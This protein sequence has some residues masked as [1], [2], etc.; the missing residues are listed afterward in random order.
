MSRSIDGRT[1]CV[2]GASSGMGRSIA[3]HLGSLGAHVFLAGRTAP[4][5]EES[6]ETIR[7]AG[8]QADTAVFDVTD[9]AALSAWIAGAAESTGRLDVMVNNAGFGDVGSTIADG[10]PDSWRSMLEVNV[11]ALA[12]G[13]QAAIRAMRSTGSEGNIINI[14][15]TASIRRES[16][17][18]GATKHAV[19]CI[20]GTLRQ[21]LEDDPI[22]VTAILPGAFA[23]NFTRS[24]DRELVS[25]LAAMAGIDVP[26]FDEDGKLPQ[27]QIDAM[28]AAMTTTIGDVSHISRAV[29][30]VIS[31]PIELNIEELIIRPQKSLF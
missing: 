21:E 4:P 31:Q 1:V 2:T 9:S 10:D 11:L 3:E 29:E 22:R 15:S 6:A 5:M 28:Q 12:V 30:F 18:Y 20:N 17:V 8:G 13:S 14:S 23:T 19:N 27:D 25:G 24:V 16:G 7:S 26:E